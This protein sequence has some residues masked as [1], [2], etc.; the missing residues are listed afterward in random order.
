MNRG[1][2]RKGRQGT[3]M[4]DP[5]TKPKGDRIEGGRWG[6]VGQGKVVAA[7]RRQLYL[8]NNKK[9]MSGGKKQN[10]TKPLQKKKI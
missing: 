8:N 7:K 9:N 5:W 4:K 10:Q 3:C 6:W 1:K 2:K